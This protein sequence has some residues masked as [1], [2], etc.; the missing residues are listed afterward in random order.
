M[1]TNQDTFVGTAAAGNNPNSNTTQ[2]IAGYITLPN[3]LILQAVMGF[4]AV[5]MAVP[6]AQVCGVCIAGP[7]CPHLV[8]VRYNL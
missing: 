3:D 2:V 7:C 5:T 1:E 8:S 4:P 6:S